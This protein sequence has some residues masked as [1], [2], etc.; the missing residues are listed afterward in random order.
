MDGKEAA[1]EMA[2]DECQMTKEIQMTKPEVR[3]SPRFRHS[4]FVI[5]STF[6]IR[7]SDFTRHLAF[8]LTK[9]IA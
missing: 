5:L 9:R 2:N 1:G 8:D 4:D 6:D 3:G 7:H